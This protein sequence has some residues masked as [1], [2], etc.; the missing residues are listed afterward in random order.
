MP[1]IQINVTVDG[2][3]EAIDVIGAAYG[4]QIDGALEKVVDAIRAG[5]FYQ[6]YDSLAV[7]AATANLRFMYALSDYADIVG[8]Y[9]KALEMLSRVVKETADEAATTT[10]AD[11]LTGFGYEI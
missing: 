6:D 9:F 5:T 11:P 3:D 1:A 8:A 10:P 4:R 7:C 2:T